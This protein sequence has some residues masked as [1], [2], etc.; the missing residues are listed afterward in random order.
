MSMVSKPEPIFHDDGK[1]PWAALGCPFQGCPHKFKVTWMVPGKGL[2]SFSRIN[3][4]L[5]LMLKKHIVAEHGGKKKGPPTIIIDD[6]S[7]P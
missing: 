6:P 1:T 4:Y 5:M 2:V 7:A 3:Y